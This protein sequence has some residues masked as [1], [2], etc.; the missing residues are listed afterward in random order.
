[1]TVL[2]VKVRKCSRGPVAD[3]AEGEL[4]VAGAGREVHNQVIQRP[5][6]R[7]CQQ[8]LD[9]TCMDKWTF[10]WSANFSSPRGRKPACMQARMQQPF[11]HAALAR[12]GVQLTLDTCQTCCLL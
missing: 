6:L 2:R 5:P 3:L 8:L 4:D 12:L 7:R 9:H 11:M 10:S 1:M